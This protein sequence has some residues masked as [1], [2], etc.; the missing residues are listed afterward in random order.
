MSLSN[1][2]LLRGNRIERQVLSLIINDVRDTS[3]YAKVLG[4]SQMSADEQT[5]H[6]NR[7]KSRVKKR[8]RRI[9]EKFDE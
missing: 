1:F 5:Q 7:V 8:L 2:A 9:G 4:V 6:V 3:A